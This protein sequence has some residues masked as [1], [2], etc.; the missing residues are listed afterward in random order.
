MKRCVHLLK[1]GYEIQKIAVVNNLFR[2]MAEP[3]ANEELFS[4]IVDSLLDWD[5][6]MQTECATSFI[7]PLQ[8]GLIDAKNL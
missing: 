2:Y 8:L 7:K 1:K 6:K 4:L 5:T 3:G